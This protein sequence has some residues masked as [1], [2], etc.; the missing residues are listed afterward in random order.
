MAKRVQVGRANR[1]R[2]FVPLAGLV[3]F[4]TVAAGLAPAATFTVTNTNDSGAGSLR[5]AILDVNATAGPPHT[6]DFNIPGAGVHTIAPTSALP[7]LTVPVVIDGTTQ[8]GFNGA[9]LIE[10]SGASAGASVNG[11]T[12]SG[13]SST[14]R[15]LVVNRFSGTGVRIDTAGGTTVAGCYI[16]TNATGASAAGNG[17]VGIGII[18]AAN[19]TVGGLVQSDRNII[20][21]NTV[22][23]VYIGNAG[24]TGNVVA[25]N[26]IGTDV[27]GTTAV[28]NLNTGVFIY[29]SR[30][31]IGGTAPGA[32]NV[33]SGNSEGV[34]LG[35]PEATGNFV[36]GNFIGTNPAGNAALPNLTGV[37]IAL[38]AT[39]NMIGGATAAAR[40]V[41][42]GNTNLGIE[43][44]AASNSNTI[45]GNYIGTDAT[46]A[47]AL[48]NALDGIRVD[49]SN[50]TQIVGNVISGHST[51]PS[52]GV[53]IT[54]GGTDNDLKGNLVGTNAAGTAA[55]PNWL[56]VNIEVSSGNTIGG[57]A[58][59][60]R[61][62]ISG[63]LNDG[64]R[65]SVG[66]TNIVQGNLIG[67]DAA[68]TAAL[69]NGNQ[70]VRLENANGNVI[71]GT[72]AGA[73][74]VIAGNASVAVIVFGSNNE[75]RNN[76]I[77]ANSAHTVALT[78]DGGV[79]VYTGTG[80][81]ISGNTILSRTAT[82]AID[83]NAAGTWPPD[84]VTA[85]DPCDADTGP[86]NLQNYPVLTSAVA[87]A[88]STTIVGTLN[89]TASTAYSLEFF[90]S[91]VC[92]ASGYGAGEQFLG[93]GSVTTDAS[94][95]GTFTV[96]VPVAV[97][98]GSVV[99]AT[100]TDPGGN[101][102]EFSA[103]TAATTAAAP[104]TTTLVSSLNP[105]L[106]G[107]AVTFTATVTGAGS[108][109]TG[110]VTFGD[111]AAT[112]GVVALSGG[113]A[114]LT[115]S[116]LTVGSHAI[117]ASYGGDTTNLASQATVLTQVVNDAPA[118]AVPTLGWAGLAIL[119]LL[120]ALV[121]VGLLARRA[122]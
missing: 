2:S 52:A 66:D 87:G 109:P 88:S 29:A 90:A 70:G 58:P 122:L 119:G 97:A 30:N 106:S 47:A 56:G 31:T 33:I 92:H 28:P 74:N 116:T 111:G 14:L 60:A 108:S 114:T 37:S 77:G 49:A 98:A 118:A 82:L 11:L 50:Q 100:A 78:N 85:N 84:G 63:N 62:V 6:I 17:L 38:G 102:S 20:S 15:A 91:P 96:T 13:G 71:G 24:A 81:T 32:R 120:M 72:L 12:I 89:S 61:N 103:C 104:T 99:T 117:S 25:G 54:G 94:C 83:L 68:G 23:G 41:I 112:L 101:T 51:Q 26:Y 27:A 1:R 67:T 36:Q 95:N 64:V 3:L 121:G 65:I 115:T 4:L 46:G 48:P 18:G 105:S 75:I 34:G 22:H 8:A 86:N 40:N 7:A 45:A 43:I 73:G 16:G 107:A 42:S 21:G 76:T 39:S 53:F 69:G 35:Y 110:N 9:P 59:G 79:H 5:Q 80:N 93:T 55:L 44:R 57:T 113:S 10:L 19:N